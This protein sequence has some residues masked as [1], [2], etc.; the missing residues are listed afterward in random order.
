MLKATN[1]KVEYK[2]NPIGMDERSPR[3]SYELLGDGSSQKMR[4][5]IVQDESKKT[6]WD[7]GF[8]NDG[9]C[10]QIVYSGAALKP[11]SRY[12]WKVYVQDESGKTACSTEKAFFET[13]FLGKK[14]T[15]KWILGKAGSCYK[16][17][18]QYFRRRFNIEKKVVKA[19][20]YA[21][22]LGLYEAYI[23]GKKVSPDLFTP[24]W[25]DYHNR[26]QYQAY[27]VTKLLKNGCNVI[28]DLLAEGY[29]L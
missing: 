21:T 6:V 25:T 22:A 17:P 2:S 18:V 10:H 28:A 8:V 5:I 11:F 13:G 27:D 9:S 7:S 20:L 23:N 14:W 12:F 1:L 29:T 24:G 16:S 19:R 4:R 15:A 26:V 3:F